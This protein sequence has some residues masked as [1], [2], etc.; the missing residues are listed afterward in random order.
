MAVLAVPGQARMPGNTPGFAAASRASACISFPSVGI[1][2]KVCRVDRAP[3][4]VENFGHGE[5]RCQAAHCCDD[6]NSKILNMQTCFATPES[7]ALIETHACMRHAPTTQHTTLRATMQQCRSLALSLSL[8]RSLSLSLP[9][10]PS[11]RIPHR[12]CPGHGR[13]DSAMALLLCE[14]AMH[15]EEAVS[16]AAE[17]ACEQGHSGVRSFGG[18]LRRGAA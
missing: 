9:L 7:R 3:S 12:P 1:P 14:P 18:A 11:P 16:R 8:I 10:I 13:G 2:T 17:A 6:K 4:F 5:H 15:S